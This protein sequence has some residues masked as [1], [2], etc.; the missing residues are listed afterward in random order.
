MIITPVRA[1][2]ASRR[3][4]VLATASI[5]LFV[6]AAVVHLASSLIGWEPVA[7]WTMALLM[8]PLAVYLASVS[9]RVRRR[10]DRR[11][12]LALLVALGF[13][14]LGDLAGDIVIKLVAFGLGH[15]AF[16]AAWWPARRA[17]LVGR[18]RTRMV[19]A[20]AYLGVAV[21]MVAVL[22]GHVGVL[23]GPIVVYAVLVSSMAL[24][25]SG[26]GP[27]GALGGAVFVVSDS[28]LAWHVFVA[29]LPFGDVGVMATY[30]AAQWLV[31]SSSRVWLVSGDVDAA[32]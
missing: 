30:L 7:G 21:T 2:V 13:C 20:G 3:S 5:A 29:P 1:A 18:Q 27:R 14:W 22:A 24:L 31:V 10:R 23:L 28:L 12:L 26:T 25:A 6:S 4:T 15:V 17:S 11:V 9:A 16:C 19:A 8:P 32:D